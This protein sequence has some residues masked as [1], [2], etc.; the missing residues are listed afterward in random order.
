MEGVTVDV[1]PNPVADRAQTPIAEVVVRNVGI[2]HR[3]DLAIHI[4]IRVLD[5]RPEHVFESTGINPAEVDAIDVD[6]GQLHPLKVPR[7]GEG[8][9]QQPVENTGL[10]GNRQTVIA[11]RKVGEGERATNT[12]GRCC[13]R[14]ALQVGEV[15]RDTGET[16]LGTIEHAVAVGVEPHHVRDVCQRCV[17]IAEVQIEDR[18]TGGHYERC[19]RIRIRIGIGGAGTGH[20]RN[21]A[22]GGQ[23]S[24][25]VNDV[26]HVGAGDHAGEQV[27]TVWRR[28]R[29]SD[30]DAARAV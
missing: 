2:D 25:G 16:G 8:G 30:S 28:P 21:Q 9:R 6:T 12:R 24:G 23:D 17:D 4:T 1:T 10:I 15:H 3:V 20:R 26:D 29:L 19:R 13:D 5:R 7:G 22:R 11:V 14:Q 27:C 18:V